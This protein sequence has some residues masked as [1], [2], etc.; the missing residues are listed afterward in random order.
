MYV[1]VDEKI[2]AKI[3]QKSKKFLTLRK[4]QLFFFAVVAPAI[5]LRQLEQNTILWQLACFEIE[6]YGQQTTTYQL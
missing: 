3:F 1:C 4:M 6:D 2:F 5:C